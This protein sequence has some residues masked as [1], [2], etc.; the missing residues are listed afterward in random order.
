MKIS[1]VTGNARKFENAQKF[2]GQFAI[3][4]EQLP[5]NIPE[6]QSCDPLEIAIAKAEAAY[7]Q[8]QRPL[9]V[10]DASWNIPALKGFPG[11][12]MKY[13]N[14]WFEPRDFINL[15]TGKADRRII[16]QDSIVYIDQFGRKVF[17]RE[18][19]GEILD[20]VAPFEY[21]HPTD[22]VF[23]LSKNHASI[24][25][26]KSKG[27]FFIEDED[28]VWKEFAAWLQNT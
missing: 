17:T 11:P 23:S 7:T 21:T 25:E 6:I 27:T 1:Y 19:V 10:N 14:Q 18:H 3:E 24:A 28:V 5:L 15:M 12:F 22:V 13:V 16:L 2:F 8:A 4:V 20:T 9:F 26:E